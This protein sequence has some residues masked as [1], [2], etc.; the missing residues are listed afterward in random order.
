MRLPWGRFSY[1][2]LTK[3]VR[4]FGRKKLVVAHFWTVGKQ[5]LEG[6]GQRVFDVWFI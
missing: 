5:G 3:R 2:A 1:V 4:F 6:E